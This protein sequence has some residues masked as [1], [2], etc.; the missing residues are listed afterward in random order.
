MVQGSLIESPPSFISLFGLSFIFPSRSLSP[1]SASVALVIVI[2]FALYT[3]FSLSYSIDFSFLSPFLEL[4]R[5]DPAGAEF[6]F[7]LISKYI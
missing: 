1:M 3:F 5:A 7:W 4:L 6:G 2:G